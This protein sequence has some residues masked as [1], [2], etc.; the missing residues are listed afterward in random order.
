MRQSMREREGSSIRHT[1][2]TYGDQRKRAAGPEKAN[3]TKNNGTWCTVKLGVASRWL[4]K[5]TLRERALTNR[6]GGDTL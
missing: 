3:R 2:C 5:I 1:W 4:S 6:V